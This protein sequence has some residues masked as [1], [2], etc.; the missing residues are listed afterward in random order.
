MSPVTVLERPLYTMGEAAKFLQVRR[1]TLKRWLDGAEIRGRT[2]PPVIRVAAKRTDEV[3]WAEFIEAG[4]LREYR[5]LDVSLQRMRGF[6]DRVR[7]RTDA[8][9]PLAHFRP[10]V[11]ENHQLLYDLQKEAD[12]EPG[13]YLVKQGE[14]TE[15]FQ[16]A[17]VVERFLQKVDFGP[18]GYAERYWPQGKGSPVAIDPEHSFGVPQVRGI[19]TEIVV[20]AIEAGEPTDSVAGEWGLSSAEVEAAV[21]WEQS[22]G[23]VAKA[24]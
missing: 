11:D 22:I 10:F 23:R 8:P 20:E 17:P 4:F 24:A 7:D 5:Q 6:L 15:E 19:R 21:A 13:L 16:L 14:V 18:D 12:L 3:T 1:D 2:Y 9:Y